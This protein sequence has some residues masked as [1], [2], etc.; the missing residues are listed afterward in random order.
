MCISGQNQQKH[1]LKKTYLCPN[2]KGASISANVSQKS[3][4]LIVLQ[5]GKK[6]E[7]NRL[8]VYVDF[9]FFIFVWSKYF[10]FTENIIYAD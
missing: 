6:I 1:L 5:N 3:V 7:K 10:K 2:G 9:Y 8:C 4:N